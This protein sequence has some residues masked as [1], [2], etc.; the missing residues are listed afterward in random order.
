MAAHL[1]HLLAT[2]RLT[3]R[4]MTASFKLSA[5][6]RIG[7]LVLLQPERR[8]THWYWLCKCDCGSVKAAREDHLR[9]R[10][11]QSCGCGKMESLERCWKARV[12]HGD[13]SR[14]GK[15]REF[16]VW[17]NMRRRCTDPLD[18]GFERYGGRGIRICTRWSSYANF[19]ADMGRMPT[20]KHTIERKNNDGNYEPS[21]CVWATRLDQ[22]N[23]RRSNHVLT[24]GGETLTIAQWSRRVGIPQ[25]TLA[26][27]IR[28]G[29]ST[30]K[31]LTQPLR[32]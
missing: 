14:K 6:T 24:H 12:V 9:S 10:K 20:P 5:G 8:K 18:A 3:F 19:I 4:D 28:R 1:R 29:W 17:V 7:R 11:T 2:D 22:A 25:L 31:S 13:C 21:N 27:R 30:A 32:K 23:N 15:A 16:Q 26:A